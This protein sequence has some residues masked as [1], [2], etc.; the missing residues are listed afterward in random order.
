MVIEHKHFDEKI[1]EAFSGFESRPPVNVWYGIV[2]GMAKPASRRLFP[3]LLKIAAGLALLVAVSITLWYFAL[4]PSAQKAIMAGIDNIEKTFENA[5]II[6]AENIEQTSETPFSLPVEA[7]QT[8]QSINENLTAEERMPALYHPIRITPVLA[9]L[10]PEKPA[11]ISSSI[12]LS[13]EILTVD[14]QPGFFSFLSDGID[15]SILSFGLQAAPQ[16]SFRNIRNSSEASKAGIPFESLE[17]HYFN[18]GFGFYLGIDLSERFKIQTGLNYTKMGQF[19]K[20]IYSF[21]HPE[22]IPFFVA[23]RNFIFGHPQTII[24]SQGSIRLSEPSLFFADAKSHR[25]ITSKQYFPDGD[26]DKLQF[27]DFGLSQQFTFLEVPL[28]FQYRLYEKQGVSLH[29]K[30]GGGISY[31]LKNEVFVA[32]YYHQRSIGETYGLRDFNFS[33]F[34]GA[35]LEIPIW[36][37]LSFDIEPNAKIFLRSMVKEVRL[38]GSVLPFQYS[39]LTRITYGF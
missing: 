6:P 25:V 4:R 32:R 9:S 31:L 21:T 15:L 10:S 37:N 36:R 28:A 27:S 35:V 24:T 22:D 38:V 39:L 29:I 26:P 19:L 2:G 1:R 30:G 13:Q 11:L 20:D 8:A 34:G 7:K 3:V 17:E 23:D 12:K 18:F 5:E 14:D 16:Y 33:A